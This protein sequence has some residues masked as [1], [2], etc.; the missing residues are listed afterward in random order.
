MTQKLLVY[1]HNSLYNRNN[2]IDLSIPNYSKVLICRVASWLIG[3][4]FHHTDHYINQGMELSA[5]VCFISIIQGFSRGDCKRATPSTASLL[6]HITYKTKHRWT[7][8]VTEW[9]P[10]PPV[11]RSENIVKAVGEQCIQLT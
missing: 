6:S 1:I 11:R 8:T 4:H 7:N 5:V 2:F 9:W 10:R 3:L